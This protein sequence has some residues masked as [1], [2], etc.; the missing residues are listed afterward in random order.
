MR[1]PPPAPAADNII[2]NCDNRFIIFH[3]HMSHEIV[4]L[5][6]FCLDQVILLLA[7][8][9]QNH[10]FAQNVGVK[11][12]G[13][14]AVFRCWIWQA[15]ADRLHAQFAA[16][17][18]FSHTDAHTRRARMHSHFVCF[19]FVSHYLFHSRHW[20]WLK[21]LISAVIKRTNFA[22][23]FCFPLDRLCLELAESRNSRCFK[24]LFICVF[25]SIYITKENKSH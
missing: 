25:H 16:A 20:Q 9:N 3:V 14:G 22:C 4:S 12:V 21:D 24:R 13:F 10:G 23:P 18:T 8:T 5:W 7:A 6:V 19:L 1:M 2:R 15:K 11:Y 17:H